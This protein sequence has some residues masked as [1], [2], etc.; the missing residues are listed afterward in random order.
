MHKTLPR[1]AVLNTIGKLCT[2]LALCSTLMTSHAHDFRVGKLVIDHPYARPLQADA[3]DSAAYLNGI[4]NRGTTADR[5]ISASTAAAERV[6]L[7]EITLQDGITRIQTI[8]AIELPAGQEVRLKPGQ[9][10]HL[11]LI[12]LRQPLVAGDRFDLTLRFEKAGEITVS[13]W[14]QQPPAPTP[15]GAHQH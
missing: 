4:H 2:T 6:E 11:A 12:N 7:R 5:L 1:R 15:S 9:R 8:P 13:V 3:S 10:W 14:V